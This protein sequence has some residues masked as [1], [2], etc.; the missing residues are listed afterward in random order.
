MQVQAYLAALWENGALV[1]TA[2]AIAC[3]KGVVKYFDSNLLECNGGQLSLT[4]HWAK[5]LMECMGFVKRRARTKSSK[6]TDFGRF[7]VQFLS[8]GRDPL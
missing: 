4:K 3:V 5:Y 7:K 6:V 2:I 1:N 8:D